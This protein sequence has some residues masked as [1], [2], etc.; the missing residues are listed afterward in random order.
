M[1]TWESQFEANEPISN[2]SA[3][4]NPIYP[5]TGLLDTSNT[6]YHAKWGIIT[7]QL[8]PF[9]AAGLR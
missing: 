4:N 3:N 7:D 1:A 8:T 9:L 5:E 6:L 2:N